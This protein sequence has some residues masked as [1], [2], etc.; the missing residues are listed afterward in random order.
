MKKITQGTLISAVRSEKYSGI[1]CYA[2]VIN[3]RCDLAQNKT[4]ISPRSPI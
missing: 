1:N 3:A 2:I 4:N